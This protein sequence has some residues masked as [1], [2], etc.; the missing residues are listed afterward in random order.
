MEKNVRHFKKW[1]ECGSDTDDP[2]NFL[3][4]VGIGNFFFL[5]SSVEMFNSAW[6]KPHANRSTTIRRGRYFAV[7]CNPL[8]EWLNVNRWILIEN[9]K[10]NLCQIVWC[11]CAG[12]L[13]HTFRS[14][15]RWIDVRLLCGMHGP[16]KTTVELI[17]SFT[18]NS[19][20]QIFVSLL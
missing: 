19:A 9:L 20:P 14:E 17:E 1:G 3:P 5:S 13:H 4:V 6:H 7:C 15:I 11:A 10:L 16:P 2:F 12:S 8:S 18:E